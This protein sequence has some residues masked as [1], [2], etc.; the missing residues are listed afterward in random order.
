MSRQEI[1]EIAWKKMEAI[2]E[3]DLPQKRR[4]FFLILPY[5]AAASFLLV[6]GFFAFF[7]NPSNQLVINNNP[8]QIQEISNSANLPFLKINKEKAIVK[9]SKRQ[10]ISVDEIAYLPYDEETTTGLFI[11]ED[12]NKISKFIAE[13]TLAFNDE[14]IVLDN[15]E[16]FAKIK[17]KETK[18]IKPQ[19]TQATNNPNDGPR[20]SID[21]E[22]NGVALV[23]NQQQN[24]ILFITPEI[25]KTFQAN[26]DM[27]LQS[28][29]SIGLVSDN[30]EDYGLRLGLEFQKPITRDVNLNSGVRYSIYKEEY[31]STYN[32]NTKEEL[33]SNLLV[34][35]LN[36]R[37]VTRNFVEI[38][39]YANYEITPELT[40]KGGASLTYNSNKSESPGFSTLSI[41]NNPTFSQDEKQEIGK[42][43]QD[44]SGY[45]GEYLVG[46]SLN[47]DKVS[48]DLE[49]TRGF[50][51]NQ[52]IENR[53]V[54][55]MR[56]SYKFG[57]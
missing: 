6:G 50:I 23:T 52:G 42:L 43:Y 26:R 41:A 16:I 22:S 39:V 7:Y 3:R 20:K 53:N 27:G 21:K 18:E 47:V 9:Q 32:T 24:E 44:Q 25:R 1:K 51:N 15:K 38:P 19:I 34:T 33:Q 12:G 35:R 8:I 10:R 37:N 4:K 56:V 11:F 14:V 49:A 28:N 55:G 17:S 45:L 48:F 2:L 13:R 40:L 46:A 54:V 36:E 30:F 31:S 57:K 5:V 29:G